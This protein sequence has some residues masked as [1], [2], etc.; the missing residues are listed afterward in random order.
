M[1]NENL[2][3]P[4]DRTPEERRESARNAG[5]ASG[6]A[7]RRKRDMKSRMK[8]ILSLPAQNTND[9]NLA[10]EM[11]V[12]LDEI[13]NEIVMLIGLFLKAK[14]G[15]VPAVREI[16]SILGLDTASKELELKKK[17]L[18]SKTGELPGKDTQININIVAA[19]GTEGI[20][21]EDQSEGADDE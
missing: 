5:K 19:K 17:E 11:G 20:T 14:Q 15:D 1:N 2:L 7:R 9:W 8:M 16:R 13:D 6:E 12:E 18:S 3:K 10:A 4:E 21:A